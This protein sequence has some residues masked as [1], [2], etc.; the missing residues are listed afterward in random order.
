MANMMSAVAHI[1]VYL[2]K[3]SQVNEVALDKTDPQIQKIQ[4][5]N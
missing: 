2:S 3:Y 4:N 5:I 1:T